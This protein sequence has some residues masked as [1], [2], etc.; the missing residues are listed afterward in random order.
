[1]LP[2][3]R[4]VVKTPISPVADGVIVE[5]GLLRRSGSGRSSAKSSF[6][7]RLTKRYTLSSGLGSQEGISDE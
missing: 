2:R 3:G 4:L 7:W 1:M 5:A 6:D